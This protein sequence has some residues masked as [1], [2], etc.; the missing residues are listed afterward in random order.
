L[1]ALKRLLFGAGDDFV[2]QV[3]ADIDKVIAVTG[4][5]DDKVSMVL[6]IFLGFTKRLSSN[7]VELDVMTVELK[8]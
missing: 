5:P 3:P 2:L 7:D 1:N 4:H 6:G 8:V